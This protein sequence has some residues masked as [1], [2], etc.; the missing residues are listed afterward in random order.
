MGLL[1]F[2]KKIRKKAKPERLVAFIAVLA[3]VASLIQPAS[4][5]HAA[6][7]TGDQRQMEKIEKFTDTLVKGAQYIDGKYVWNAKTDADDH[8]FTFR[9]DYAMSGVK[10]LEPGAIKIWI[11][12]TIL[13]DRSGKY[14]DYMDLSIPSEDEYNSASKEDRK[15][16]NYVWKEST[17]E[18]HKNCVEITNVTQR[19]AG[20]NGY[21]EVAY[22]T[23]EQTFEYKDEVKYDADQ[24]KYTI[25]EKPQSDPFYADI[26]VTN[27]SDEKPQT[28]TASADRIPVY[29]NTTAEISSTDKRYPNKMYRKWQSSWGKQPDEAKDKYF[30]VWEIV[31]KIKDPTQPFTFTLEDTP[32]S[33]EL[34]LIGYSMGLQ[35]GP[36]KTAKENGNQVTG[37]RSD[38]DRYDYVLTYYDP[39]EFTGKDYYE[40]KNSVKAT[41][42]PED[43]IDDPTSA[44][45]SKMWEWDTPKFVHPTGHFYGEKYGDNNWYTKFGYYHDYSSYS[46]DKMQKKDI[47][48]IDTFR[49]YISDF[50]YPYP[51]T[52]DGDADNP[53]SYGNKKVTYQLSDDELYLEDKITTKDV[54]T[55]QLEF[56]IPEGAH[57][58]DSSDY[59]FLYADW[60]M[61]SQF[62]TY[63]DE[64]K[65]FVTD[66]D[67]KY[68]DG[69][70]V[71]FWVKTNE[72]DSHDGEY[73]EVA[74]YD[75]GSGKASISDSGIVKEL[76]R[77]RITFKSDKDDP[78]VTGIRFTTSNAY[79]YTKIEA[80]P[81]VRLKNSDYV[82]KKLFRDENPKNVTEDNCKNLIRLHNFAQSNVYQA[83]TDDKIKNDNLIYGVKVYAFDRAIR[84]KKESEIHKHI[85]STGSNK[86]KKKY[87]IRWKITPRET[88][89]TDSGTDYLV[90]NS[91]TFYDL[92]PKGTHLE[93][94]SVDVETEK[95]MLSHSS[96]SYSVEED[97]K[98]SGRDL[99]KVSVPVQA[100]YYNLYLNAEMSWDAIHDYGTKINNPVAYE[101]GNDEIYNG[102][103]DDDY[104]DS[105]GAVH[106]LPLSDVNKAYMT[107]LDPDCTTNRFIYDEEPHDIDTLTAAVSGLK[108]QI[109]DE[110]DSSYSYETYTTPKGNYSYRIRFANTMTDKAKNMIFFDSL[111]NY[112]LNGKHSDWH[113][114]LKRFDVSQLK[115]KGIE[116]VIYVS[117]K[118][119]LS[120]EGM[121][122]NK[123]FPLDDPKSG[124]QE[125]GWQKVTK[126]TNL[127]EMHAFAIDCRKTSNGNDDFVLNQGE[128]IS[129][130]VYMQAPASVAEEKEGQYDKTYPKAYNNIYIQDTI[131]SGE[132]SSD[133]FIH[134]DYT[135]I[136]YRVSAD[137]SIHK[138]N[139]DNANESIEG[140]KYTLKGTSDY[141]TEVNEEVTTGKQGDAV[142]EG[143][144]KGTYTLKESYSPIDWVLDRTEY[145][146]KVD[147]SGKITCDG[148]EIEKTEKITLKDSPRIH[149][150]ISFMKY[151]TAGNSR[152][153]T[154]AKFRLSG[155][156][157]YGTDVMEY[158][159]S[160]A[161]GKVKFENIEWGSYKLKEVE[162]PDGYIPDRTEY[163]AVVSDSGIGGIE[164][165]EMLKTGST[166]IRNEPYHTVEISKQSSYNSA[167]LSGA[168]FKLTGTSDY[169]TPYDKTAASG[170]NGLAEFTGLEAGTYIIQETKSPK[171]YF[172]DS[173]KH[174]VKVNKDDTYTIDGLKKNGS[175]YYKMENKREENGRI[176]VKK[177]WKDNKKDGERPVPTIHITT[178]INKVPTYAELRKD[179]NY[180][181]DDA[182]WIVG[183]LSSVSSSYKSKT[184]HF[185]YS[186]ISEKPDNVTA[187]RLDKNFNDPDA[188][189]KIYGWLTNDGTMHYWTNAQKI[190]MTNDDCH[191][192]TGM[193]N[194]KSVD[195]SRIDVSHMTD[196][197]YM[198]CNCKSLESLDLSGFKNTKP[199]NM[200]RM[201]EYCGKLISLNLTQIDMS[202]VENIK[203][204][205]G[206]CD[207]L[208]SLKLP[209]INTVASKDADMSGMFGS[210]GSLVSLTLLKIDTSK[211]ES[212]KMG[213]MFSDCSK[214]TSLDLSDWNTLKV[215]D[216]GSMFSGCSSLTS[217][218]LS[219]FKTSNVTD[220]G[221][222]FSDCSSLTSLDLSNFK[223]SNVTDMS[224]MFDA[225]ASLTSLNVSS[226]KTTKVKNMANMFGHA[227]YY[228]SEAHGCSKL[229]SLN[230]SNF[231]T[232]EVENM[233]GMFCGCSSLSS[234]DVSSFKTSK[235]QRMD[236]MFFACTSL[237]EIIGLSGFDTRAVKKMGRES[238]D[239]RYSYSDEHYPGYD[240]QGGMFEKCCKLKS[241][242]LSSF[243]TSKV[244]EMRYMFSD[245]YSL[246]SLDLSKFDT[247]K[248][249]DMRG[250]FSGCSGLTSLDL[251]LFDTS[252]VT[253]MSE[254]FFKCSGLTSLNLSNF[255]TSNVTDMSEMFFECSGLTSLN[256]SNFN[257]SNVTNMS[258][259][260]YYCSG[261]TSLDVSNFDTSN[262]TDMHCMF[263]GCSSLTSIYVSNKWNT[264]K[265]TYSFQMFDRC[266]NLPNYSSSSTDK[267]HA[268]Y[269]SDG[270]LTYKAAPKA[271]ANTSNISF[272]SRLV[273]MILSRLAVPVHAAD[274]ASYVSTD[275]DHCKITKDG[276]TWTYEFSVAD[277]SAKYYAYEDDMDGYTSSVAGSYG[278]ATKDEPLTITNTADDISEEPKLA[279][280]SLSKSADGKQLVESDK[281]V[282]KYSHTSNID[283]TGKA[284]GTYNNYLDT[285][286]IV[287]IP[288]ASK[289][290]VKLYCSTESVSYDWACVWAGSHPDYTADGNYSSSK[291]GSSSG[292]IGDNGYKTSMP[293]T[294]FEEGDI[295]GDSVTFGF[296]S[297]GSVGYYGYYAVV[298]GK[299]ADGNAITHKVKDITDD[300][301]IED[302]PSSYLDKSYM[303]DITLKN[304][305]SSKLSGTK[306]FGD[307]IFTD[308]KAQVGVKAGE[309]KTFS[310][311]PGG[312]TYT[313][314]EKKYDDFLTE[315]KNA[316]GTLNAGDNSKAKFTNHYQKP[317]TPDTPK[318]YSGFTLKKNVTGFFQNAQN[319]TFDVSFR[320]L[321]PNTEYSLSN[322]TKFTS[323]ADGYGYVQTKL[324]D[325]GLV[326]FISLPVGAQYKVTE[327]GGDWSS[328]YRITNSTD[329]GEIAQSAGSAE[330]NES[331]STEWETA[332][333]GEGIT[334]TYTN[335]VKKYQNLILK[336]AV[337]GGKATDKFRFTVEFKKLY[338]TV[339]SDAGTIV[340]DDDGTAS[341]DVYLNAG[342]EIVFKNIPVTAKYRFTEKAN[343]GKASYTI[344]T[345]APDGVTG[346]KFAKSA[347]GNTEAMKDLSTATET[348]DEGE[349]ATVTFL[350]DM[351]KT[352]SV[353]LKK[354]V[355]G[356]FADRNKFFKFTVSLTGADKKQ[357]YS[358]DYT[359]GSS[360][361]DG[362]K[363]VA[364]ITT[365]ENGNGTADIWLKHND[366]VVIKDIPL[367]A[368]YSIA[369]D[370]GEYVPGITIN[371]EKADSVSERQAAPDVI[372]F[373]N[374]NT[375][376][377]PT[378]LRLK[379]T[380]SMV[381]AAIIFLVFFFS[382]SSYF[383][384]KRKGK[385]E[386]EEK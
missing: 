117:E 139:A 145:T 62:R 85:V 320:K 175:G 157:K 10:E 263:Y 153:V 186:D 165:A 6:D 293:A 326:T 87:V 260:F 141:G 102:Y 61:Y 327:E 143:I 21:F 328:T 30:L 111:E 130:V 124:W 68:K 301:P 113:G 178:D 34:H 383:L 230:L 80:Y 300:S 13:K 7:D 169:G 187:V 11:P 268:N 50:G 79:Y 35:N 360:T 104:V 228:S 271:K 318:E 371:G 378:G 296:R 96:F 51:W 39:A 163:T 238:K 112:N 168:E 214:L 249:T 286:D 250:M 197:S 158:A 200:S 185:E 42:T 244:D 162:A 2:Y 256:L 194:M 101:T 25:N 243:D 350:N 52:R 208:T 233:S 54:G 310:S 332:D 331:L 31:S 376:I 344:R 33:K 359:K 166:V 14:A 366:T 32:V 282:E 216:M 151:S 385:N 106:K 365:D 341:V 241:I 109:K 352:T 304:S 196:M 272:A 16:V 339:S 118:E 242:D 273:S 5:V 19:T 361:H 358:F 312:T 372:V 354:Q 44:N 107:K 192:F 363:N 188:R 247:S 368:K 313:I 252:N 284:N 74:S 75:L 321:D 148:K 120:F 305:D 275:K 193:K 69:D 229:T 225:C 9:V 149:G 213:G 261:L 234:I 93:K 224:S 204:M 123:E 170:E 308:G 26:S 59:Q 221:G 115:Q 174:I 129:A 285:N 289:L 290:H 24:N 137:I 202:N 381:C 150:D 340:P 199:E 66:P 348:V 335:T 347:D 38:S 73:K 173:T 72:K 41:V 307:T 152:S 128:S 131:M 20:E 127:S 314:T 369:E 56:G 78:S 306:I 276:D 190:R 36:F 86:I 346:G 303:F 147:S 342:D 159:T 63:K 77:D 45:S 105:S 84:P 258:Y 278:I 267:T 142:F 46:L 184:E 122:L 353:T 138:Q 337:T 55:D 370:P 28:V 281:P 27:I 23:N 1:K 288:G 334:V 92:L 329:E 232:S 240:G 298:T 343:A 217:L 209:E 223:T 108:K 48:R 203:R 295:D 29:I 211:S 37:Q 155:K 126:S 253:D 144:E 274:S 3:M 248:V 47:N 239:G 181:P 319:Y 333:S 15:D 324:S 237:S 18:A 172:L 99:I 231:E 125:F 182:Y 362:T 266:S 76:T 71:H 338:E 235:V 336:K 356:A 198:F 133:F 146:V 351:P 179:K 97:Y 82:M 103:P 355:S 294:P 70:V 91:G 257:T 315:S 386:K 121:K 191:L 349:N 375:A 292:K 246:T 287:T 98:N 206:S 207:S 177:K 220:M 116:P 270:Y 262:V 100:K 132:T 380:I 90:Q 345:D 171:D 160:D 219:N 283:D 167:P 135:E 316:S 212:V 357:S 64:E 264:D 40:L 201:F 58:L 367:S 309:T 245:C 8:R 299:D 218:D 53:K 384:N 251:S 65:K 183:A 89:T 311:L 81:M 265:V 377:L 17:D 374:T 373:T 227:H 154:G 110:H 323:D 180:D 297:D 222:M 60:N 67:G 317:K 254:M 94:G 140:A 12:K 95:G 195:L 322:G 277:D 189:F 259:M 302:V 379:T 156:S 210:C 330:K 215:T 22:V 325:K 291:L 161:A 382:Y 83:E 134:Q 269:G 57:R 49:Y 279:S 280:L 88:L 176:I 164:D 236:G 114:I 364:S 136:R 226:F 119:N 205:F 255:N 4:I 43:G